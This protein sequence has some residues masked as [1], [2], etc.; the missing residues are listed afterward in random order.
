M[1]DNETFVMRATKIGGKR[2]PDDY[3]VWWRGLAIGRIMKSPGLPVHVDQ[4][5]WGCNVY[6]QPS[7]D[8]D[9]GQGT[10]L[11]DCMASF[12]IAWKRIRAGL[13]DADVARAYE[14]QRSGAT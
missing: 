10:S 2:Y 6:G 1:L 14:I 4:W 5:S 7:L 11:E 12:K 9:S 8:G 13:T 3:T